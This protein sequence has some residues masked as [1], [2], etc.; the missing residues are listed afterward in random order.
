[1]CSSDLPDLGPVL[2]KYGIP[3]RIDVKSYLRSRKIPLPTVTLDQEKNVMNELYE[4]GKLIRQVE[5]KDGSIVASR[6]L[7]PSITEEEKATLNH[8]CDAR[9]RQQQAIGL[10]TVQAY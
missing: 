6:W 9:F 5:L 1:M 8:L 4:F 10:P 3:T 2:T 7:K